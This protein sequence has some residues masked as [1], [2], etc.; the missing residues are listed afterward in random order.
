M[1]QSNSRYNIQQ[2]SSMDEQIVDQENDVLDIDYRI[3]IDKFRASQD[4]L[5]SS[6]LLQ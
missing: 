4:S 3:M 6:G 5:A 1:K 2:Q